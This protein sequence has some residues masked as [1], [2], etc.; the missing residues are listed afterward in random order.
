M[1][2]ESSLNIATYNMEWTSNS[3]LAWSFHITNN[4]FFGTN[5]VAF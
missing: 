4:H 1:V 2:Y 5:F 3:K